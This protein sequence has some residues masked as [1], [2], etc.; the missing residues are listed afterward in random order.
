[1]SCLNQLSE[2]GPLGISV[3]GTVGAPLLSFVRYTVVL[4]TGPLSRDNGPVVNTTVYL[5][6]DSS[7]APT[8]PSTEIPNGPGSDNWFRQLTQ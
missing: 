3:D 5:T 8:V 1:M 6:K 4:T 7:G 2:P